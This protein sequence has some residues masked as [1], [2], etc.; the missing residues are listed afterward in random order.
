M[1]Y[2]INLTIDSTEYSMSYS[3]ARNLYNQLS[4]IFNTGAPTV[5]AYT[6]M[7]GFGGTTGG[8][9]A[10]DSTDVWNTHREF[11]TAQGI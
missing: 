9:M 7:G 10:G 4:T 2:T 8:T 6:G 1:N 11:V 5:V 3:D